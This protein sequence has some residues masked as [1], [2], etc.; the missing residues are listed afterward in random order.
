MKKE[1]IIPEMLIRRVILESMIAQSET[2]APIG[3]SGDWDGATAR[4]NS[5]W[6]DED[7]SDNIWE[8]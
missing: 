1:Y 7:E 6:D 3:G 8:D 5:N 2:S 4:D